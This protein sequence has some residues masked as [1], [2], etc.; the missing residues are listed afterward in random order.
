MDST[1][2]EQDKSCLPNSGAESEEFH[3]DH[4]ITFHNDLK[5][6]VIIGDCVPSDN[7]DGTTVQNLV[8]KQESFQY[9]FCVDDTDV[10]D[11]VAAETVVTTTPPRPRQAFSLDD[12]IK[13]SPLC[14][15]IFS[16]DH[17][18]DRVFLDHLQTLDDANV[19]SQFSGGKL[20][21]V[22]E[23]SESELN[24]SQESFI[25]LAPDSILASGTEP[26]DSAN[27]FLGH[28]QMQQAF[29]VK[30]EA[31]RVKQERD[32]MQKRRQR[33][34][35]DFRNKEK[36]KAKERMRNKR[37]N[38]Q[39]RDVER[40]KDRV[41][42]R[43]SRH[44]TAIQKMQENGAMENQYQRLLQNIDGMNVV[45]EGANNHTRFAEPEGFYTL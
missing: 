34:N 43:V 44:R 17:K 5:H 26:P 40:K 1:E 2:A 39:Y 27:Q 35:P 28:K 31:R 38:P 3:Q 20:T 24:T 4:V 36:E 8:I 30:Q 18:T 32:R 29:E 9:E 16:P 12:V 45:V 37:M 14:V 42:R 41:R 7:A 6:A 10:P 11:I 23:T 15:K 22:E 19:W 33:L 25:A 21:S 13:G